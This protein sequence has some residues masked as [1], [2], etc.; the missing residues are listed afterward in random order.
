MRRQIPLAVVCAALLCLG[1][2]PAAASITGATTTQQHTGAFIVNLNEDGSAQITLQ[3]AYDLESDAEQAAFKD[4]KNNETL[5]QETKQNFLTRMERV[6][7]SAENATGREMRVSDAAI[8]FET[9]TDGSVG[10]VS[11]SVTWTG[12]A[13]TNGETLTITEPFA[14]GFEPE[15]PFTVRGPDGYALNSATPEPKATQTNSATW[16]PGTEL[17][18]FEAVFTPAATATPTATPSET[19]TGGGPGFGVA[20]TVLA[21]IGAAA[22]VLRR[23]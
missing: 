2:A 5:Q 17:T 23:Q 21:L 18:D 8:A 15:R 4:L 10:L 12:L 19:T 13:A 1:A 7:A 3:L 14:S 16:A 11:L 9:T 22:V 20:V 6:A